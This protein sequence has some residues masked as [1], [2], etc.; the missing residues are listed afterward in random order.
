MEI[1]S[2]TFFCNP[3][4]PVNKLLLQK[5]GIFMRHARAA[6]E[7]AGFVV[8]TV[9]LA[10]PPFPLYLQPKN[11]LLGAQTIAF[12]AHGEGFDYF[13]IG[14][15]LAEF[16][17]AYE[18]IP[19]ILSETK[20]LFVSGLTTTSA[21][22]L[23]QPAIRACAEIMVKAAVLEKDGFANLRFASLANVPAYAPFFPAA[24]SAEAQ[25]AFALAIE[26]AD[27]AVQ[28]FSSATTLANARAIL[29][30]EIESNA[31][32][33]EAVADQLQS[34][35]KYDFKGLD[36]TLAPFPKENLS[37]GTAIQKI[38]LPVVGYQGTLA[39]SAFVTDTLD[40]AKF[41]R[42]GFNGLMLPV[43]EDYTLGQ[44]AAQ[45][46]LAVSDLL[47]F[48]AVCGTGLD[49]IPLPG[50]TSA[51]EIYPVLL[52]L[53]ALALRLNKPLTARLLPMPGKKAGDE[54][55]FDF[56]YFTNTRVM[57]LNA[58]PLH[59]LLAGQELLTI[60]PRQRE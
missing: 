38:G 39:A 46:T 36:F 48:S 59:G 28:A 31:R 33:L 13:S 5:A 35:Y 22:Q 19:T 34:I 23:S 60:S 40:Q 37:I 50:D 47:L 18:A 26:A 20:G 27:L 2:I 44:S 57:L 29:I 11:Y 7:K 8:Q 3:G 51:E 21:G 24:Y 12:E 6:Y 58:K 42:C 16:P 43:L 52:D 25:P 49:V 55:N 56:E 45:G 1:R 54:T 14:P 10:T 4:F 17:S 15:A 9:R 30:N 32:K 53:S 41:K